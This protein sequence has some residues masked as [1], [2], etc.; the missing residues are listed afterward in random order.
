FLY[1]A[2]GAMYFILAVM[3]LTAGVKFLFRIV[4]LWFLIM[5]SPLAFLSKTTTISE[6]YYDLWQHKLITHTFYPVVFLFIFLF[7]ALFMGTLN[8]EGGIIGGLFGQLE[9]MNTSEQGIAGLAA[10]VANVAIRLGFVVAMLYIGMK[11]ADT[12]GVYGAGAAKALTGFVSRKGTS[13]FFG[14]SAWAMRNSLGWAGNRFATSTTGRNLYAKGGLLGRTFVRGTGALGRQSFA[15]RGAPGVRKGLGLVGVDTTEAT[16]KGGYQAAFDARVKRREAAASQLKPSKR[17]VEEAQEKAIKEM[18][19]EDQIGL[20]TAANRYAEL[21]K[22]ENA[23]KT[24][25]KE[26]KDAFKRFADPVAKRAKEIAGAD[27]DKVFADSL[28]KRSWRNM[29]KVQRVGFLSRADNEVA[30]RIRGADSDAERMNMILKK[31][32]VEPLTIIRPTRPQIDD[33]DDDDDDTPTPP[34]GGSPGRG[35]P[36]STPAGGGGGTPRGGGGPTGGG[37]RVG[38]GGGGPTAGG[39]RA[40]G[41]GSAFTEAA[42]TKDAVQKFEEEHLERLNEI[43]DRI[44]TQQEKIAHSLDTLGTK[45]APQQPR[46]A[47]SFVAPTAPKASVPGTR[48]NSAAVAEEMRKL[49]SSL[50]QGIKEGFSDVSQK[51]DT[52]DLNQPKPP[53][54]QNPPDTK[55][56]NTDA[57]A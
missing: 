5:V 40:G 36:S 19:E 38:G 12:V 8:S 48:E 49:R 20:R 25:R 15:V 43:G 18:S 37:P 2:V 10:M 26:A 6:K 33:T 39:P 27:N 57:H 53:P 34:R 30:T 45:L 11:A 50:R 35:G 13:A 4:V 21:L 51:L 52:I 55:D 29:W 41:G 17:Q 47:T 46:P 54:A 3:F 9:R 44:A 1:I 24:Q 23:T 42:G 7:I 56:E 16:G 22:D 32:D 31:M 28:D 14:S